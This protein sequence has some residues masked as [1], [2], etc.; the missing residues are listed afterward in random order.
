MTCSCSKAPRANRKA[1]LL[2]KIFSSR[3]PTQLK[4]IDQVHLNLCYS[5]R[6]VTC[7]SAPQTILIHTYF[8][9]RECTHQYHLSDVP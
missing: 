3:G 9:M 5:A 7:H 1:N 6:K 2:V 8:E 4:P